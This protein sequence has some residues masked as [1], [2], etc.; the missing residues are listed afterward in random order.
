[1]GV[2][3]LLVACSGKA[4]SA[5]NSGATATIHATD[6]TFDKGV[7]Q[8]L[9]AGTVHFVLRNDSKRIVHELW[10]Y[11]KDQPQLQAML[12]AKRSGQDVSETDF[13]QGV[14]GNVD[15]LPAGKTGT[16]DAQLSPG[17]YEIA[18]FQVAAMNG[19]TMVHYDMGMH[20]TFTVQ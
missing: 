18:C 2:L 10:V 5:V 8:T 16:F 13:L 6:F 19:Q 11:P 1:M 17:T 4:S 7:P 15:N 9:A 14:V 12:A 3:T 20:A